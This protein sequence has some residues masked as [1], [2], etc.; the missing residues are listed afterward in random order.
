M[1]PPRM[2]RTRSSNRGGH[3]RGRGRSHRSPRPRSRTVLLALSVLSVLATGCEERQEFDLWPI[4]MTTSPSPAHEFAWLSPADPRRVDAQYGEPVRTEGRVRAICPSPFIEVALGFAIFH[5]KGVHLAGWIPGTNGPLKVGGDMPLVRA[6]VRAWPD[7]LDFPLAALIAGGR[8][9][10]HG[11]PGRGDAEPPPWLLGGQLRL[12]W[13]D[14]ERLVIGETELPADVNPWRV[15]AA[16]FAGEENLLV[17]VYNR[18]PFD[19]VARRRPWV[20]R[21]VEGEDGLP[22]LEARWRG[23]SFA[24]PFRAATFC[25]LSG[26][27]EGEI[28]ALEV[29]ED[30]GRMLTAYRFE[31]FGLE[32]IAPSVKLPAVEDRLEAAD[33]VG[34]REQ[35]LV[36]RCTNGRFVFF[37]LDSE[38]EELSEALTVEGPRE[39]LGW[40]V[41]D[42]HGGEPG[43]ILCVLRDGETWWADSWQFDPRRNP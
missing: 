35:E 20:Y 41:T 17:F 4:I 8:P 19:D 34:G 39:V 2:G 7:G 31:G 42:Q 43:D 15:R 23:T 10:P 40:V 37:Q 13:L 1:R 29:A 26:S 3:P 12:A 21:V 14:E 22:H 30:G 9:Q 6:A 24:H 18:A 11:L 25:D 28:A 27:G 5:D 38:A 36:V 33:W 16:R 32:G